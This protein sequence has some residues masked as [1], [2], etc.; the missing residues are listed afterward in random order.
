[1]AVTKKISFVS[2][3]VYEDG[4]IDVLER[5]DYMEGGV[6][7]S[8]RRDNRRIDVGDSVASEDQLVKDVVSGNLHNKARKDARQ[9]AKEAG[10]Q[11]GIL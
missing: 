6:V 4:Q 1:M 10:I 2:M 8:G 11:P 9:A 7:M 3:T 5:T